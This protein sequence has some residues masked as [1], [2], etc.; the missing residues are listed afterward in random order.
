MVEEDVKQEVGGRGEEDVCSKAL[1]ILLNSLVKSDTIPMLVWCSECSD[2]VDRSIDRRGA[3][4]NSVYNM[5][6]NERTNE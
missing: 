2:L 4:S 6:L 3:V 1:P 5:W